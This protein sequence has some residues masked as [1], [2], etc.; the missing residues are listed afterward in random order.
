MK[1][2]LWYLVQ[3][4]TWRGFPAVLVTSMMV[5]DLCPGGTR[6]NRGR[7]STV[8]YNSPFRI[9]QTSDA[10]Q[11]QPVSLNKLHSQSGLVLGTQCLTN[12]NTVVYCFLKKRPAVA[13]LTTSYF[14]PSTLLSRPSLIRVQT[15]SWL[16]LIPYTQRL[17]QKITFLCLAYR[18]PADGVVVRVHRYKVWTRY[19][20]TGLWT[21]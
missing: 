14:T 8:L 19:T 4:V 18:V 9:I 17:T 12:H 1:I 5:V 2:W 16:P 11:S 7:G 21:Q 10:M 15:P 6:S 20:G 13:S 3:G